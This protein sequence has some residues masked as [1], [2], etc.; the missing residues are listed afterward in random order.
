MG[1]IYEVKISLI[2]NF[3]H[4][5]ITVTRN[6]TL[7]ESV[8]WYRVSD[9]KCVTV[10]RNYTQLVSKFMGILTIATLSTTHTTV[11]YVLCV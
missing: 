5:T 3:S 9:Y 6:I 1:K 4:V 7:V 11:P 8:D 2:S 10:F